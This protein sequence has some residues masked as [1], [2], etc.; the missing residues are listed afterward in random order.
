M[1]HLKHIKSWSEK[2]NTKI[3]KE[4]QSSNTQSRALMFW[5]KIDADEI[6][7]RS[8]NNSLVKIN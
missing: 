5:F 4:S 1:K 2:F 6:I 7:Q 8:L 3:I